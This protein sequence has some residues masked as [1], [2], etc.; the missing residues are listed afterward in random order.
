MVLNILSGKVYFGRRVKFTLVVSNRERDILQK[1]IR[2]QNKNKILIS[3]TDSREQGSTFT[4]LLKAT[5]LNTSTLTSCL[6]ELVEENS[7]T[8]CY[9]PEKKRV[10]YILEPR[11]LKVILRW[12][13]EAVDYHKAEAAALKK[14][15]PSVKARLEAEWEARKQIQKK[16]G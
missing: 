4:E 16:R 1:A 6:N 12:L 13:R 8:K 5:K 7:L 3:I 14:R 10:I 9:S 15:I 2:N 11:N